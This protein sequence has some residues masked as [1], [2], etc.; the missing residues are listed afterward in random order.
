M[1]DLD[2]CLEAEKE[3]SAIEGDTIAIALCM[4]EDAARYGDERAAATWMP[5]LKDVGCKLNA[6]NQMWIQYGKEQR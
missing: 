6:L 2:Q 5:K 4:V 1:L 3:R